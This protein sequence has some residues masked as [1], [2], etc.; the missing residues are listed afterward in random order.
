MENRDITIEEQKAVAGKVEELKTICTEHGFF[1]DAFHYGYS[2][3]RKFSFD[4]YEGTEPSY[5]SK[6][7]PKHR[8]LKCW[9][10]ERY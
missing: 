7:D 5:D 2:T 1:L 9:E 6:S 8:P 4:L 3:S 10:K